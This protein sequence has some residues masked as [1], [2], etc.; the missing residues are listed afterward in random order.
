MWFSDVTWISKHP[1]PEAPPLLSLPGS[2]PKRL[3]PDDGSASTDWIEF[4]PY[5][6]SYE[7]GQV[8]YYQPQ[9]FQIVSAGKDKQYGSGGFLHPNPSMAETS[10]FKNYRYFVEENIPRLDE[11]Q[12]NYDNITNI[13][14]ARVVP[15]P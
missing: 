5:I 3:N 6:E 4:D 13:T 15:R 10:I 12:A 9:R 1:Q 7:A 2:S 14:F 11:Y 8:K